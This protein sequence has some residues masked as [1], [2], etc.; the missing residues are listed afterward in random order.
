MNEH[1]SYVETFGPKSRRRCRIV[2]CEQGYWNG[3]DWDRDATKARLFY[4]FADAAR[5]YA[6]V[7]AFQN[8]DKPCKTYRAPVS[9][10]VADDDQMDLDLG[11][12]QDHLT[13]AT[14]LSLTKPN[15]GGATIQITIHWDQMELV[16]ETDPPRE[17]H[18]AS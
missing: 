13:D 9:I 6:L 8:L 15:P 2:D 12:L 16:S 14:K 10:M 5:E 3:S 17:D 18:S 11:S 7:Q 1:K 4:T